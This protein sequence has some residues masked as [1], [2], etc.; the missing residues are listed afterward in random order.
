[1]RTTI[2]LDDRLLHAAKRV[3]AQRG[4]TLSEVVRDALRAQLAAKPELKTR[5]FKLITF[6]GAGPRPGIDIDR[7]SELLEIEDLERYSPSKGASR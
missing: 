2:T 6:R 5:R 3:A 7:T 4:V 1:M